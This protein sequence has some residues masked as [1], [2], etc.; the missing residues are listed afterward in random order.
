M[1]LLVVLVGS[2]WFMVGG[3]RF[4]GVVLTDGCR[5]LVLIIRMCFGWYLFVTDCRV[6]FR[7]LTVDCR[8]SLLVVAVGAHCTVGGCLFAGVGF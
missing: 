5:E 4:P 1:S 2:G 8:V 6:F 7:V 3:C